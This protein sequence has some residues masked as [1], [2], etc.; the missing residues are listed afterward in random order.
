MNAA[1]TPGKYILLRFRYDSGDD[2]GISTTTG[3]YVD[4]V[5]VS[6]AV[7][8]INYS[9][10]KTDI[11]CAGVNT[12]SITFSNVFGGTPPYQYSINGGNSFSSSST[13]NGLTAASYTLVIRDAVGV[14]SYISNTTLNTLTT[15]PAPVITASGSTSFCQGGG[16]N[17]TSNVIPGVT[18]NWFRSG[19]AQTEPSNTVYA[20][21]AGNW[22]VTVSLNGC[23]RQSNVITVTQLLAPLPQSVSL[24][25]TTC[26]LNNGSLTVTTVQRGTAPFQYSI[27]GGQTF[28]TSN[29]FTGLSAGTYS[30]RVRD[31][32]QC[33]TFVTT[34]PYNFTI[35]NAP[36]NINPV[37]K[38]KNVI[39][40][41]PNTEPLP[42]NPD[43]FDDGST[44]NCGIV[45]R[46]VTPSIV[47][48]NNIG[49]VPITL[50][51]KDASGRS[52][53]ANANLTLIGPLQLHTKNIN[54]YLGSNGTVSITPSDIDSASQNFT[55]LSV[56]P[57]TFNC[58]TLGCKTV[59]LSA[60]SLSGTASASAVVTVLDTIKPTAQ[61]KNISVLLGASGTVTITPSMIDFG[62]TDNCTVT[63][64]SVHPNTFGLN[65]VGNNTVTLSVSDSSGNTSTAEAVVTVINPTPIAVSKNT[66][67][68]LN[69]SGTA[70]LLPQDI[71]NGSSNYD[72]LT[73]SKSIFNCIQA[74]QTDTVI[75]TA[76]NSY[77]SVSTVSLVT[78]LDTIKPLA[79]A[80]NISVQLG[81]NG[82]VSI[83]PAMVDFGSSDNCSISFMSVSPNSF[84]TNNVGNNTVTLLVSDASGNF[85]TTEA[86]VTVINPVPL[87]ATKNINLFLNNEGLATLTPEDIDNGSSNYEILSV[88]KTLF[89][90]A[91][92][93]NIDTVILTATNSYGTANAVSLVTVL[94]TIKPTVQVKSIT[95]SLTS[96]N[97][98]TI[99]ANEIN[100][101]SFDNCMITS[102][103]VSPST[104]TLN[105]LGQNTVTLT[106]TDASGNTSSVSAVVTITAFVAPPTVITRNRTL[107]LNS[108][109]T[110]T[111]TPSQ[112]DNGSNNYT[113]LSVSPNTFNCSNVGPNT[114]TLTATGPGGTVS[115]TAI[116]TVR[117]VT[118]PTL[119]T[120][121]ISVV[122]QNGIAVITPQ[123]IDNGSTDACGIAS[124]TLN[125]TTFTLNNSNNSGCNSH[126]GQVQNVTLTVRDVNNNTASANAFVTLIQPT[127]AK[128]KNIT[129]QLNATGTV[130]I[131]AQQVNDGSVNFTSLTVSPNTFNCS[132]VG[133]NLVVL[134]AVGP[135]GTS[136]D[137]AIVTVRD[138]NNPIARAKNLTV[139]LNNG[140]AS[141]TPADIDNG[142]T[143][144]CGIA[145]MS[146]SK[147]TF[148]NSNVGNNTVTLTV[149]DI[150][151]L[152]S[153][154]TATVTVHAPPSCNI[155]LTKGSG[156]NNF[157]P[158]NQIFLGYGNQ[159]VI[160]TAQVN[161]ATAS[162][163]S[164]SGSNINNTSGTSTTFT[165]TTTGTF[166]ITCNINLQGGG[167]VSCNTTICVLDARAPSNGNNQKIFVCHNNNTLSVS[168]N[169]VPALLCNAGARL[170]SCNASCG[171]FS[172]TNDA[173]VNAIDFALS[174]E[175]FVYP[176]PSNALRNFTFLFTS[177][178]V[179]PAT[180]TIYD[181]KGVL[182]SSELITPNIEQ[183]IGGNLNTGMYFVMVKQ[184]NYTKT[185][186]ITKVN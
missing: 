38:A 40:Q 168:I 1:V 54:A 147:T 33:T 84:G 151:G 24:T 103:V 101:G 144:A 154:A 141:I 87:A 107:N 99:L 32:N 46:T 140:S 91:Q 78:V 115:A 124:M 35:S 27:N 16:V 158:A 110:L 133:Q 8:P 39:L 68:Y 69:N 112:I 31:A 163:I 70:T 98:I 82:M 51:V 184:G 55:T 11:Q 19:F 65:N 41:M 118:A 125:K 180:I 97:T 160:L 146:L 77:S 167:S 171:S 132:N 161:N 72:V 67:L 61:A 150:N 74:G 153:T 139:M 15:I 155:N 4:N 5:V 29:T 34:N 172:K 105:N 108:Q 88:S 71:D 137:T 28:T 164:W 23:S 156:A 57:N 80:K 123:D 95:K 134:T 185:L 176:N 76:T 145:S 20:N 114:V 18:Y 49:N 152:V 83:N 117:D 60:T 127:T 165:A 169:A 149:V 59:T 121:N 122:L 86:I 181:M 159:T 53:S 186:K 178:S 44:D 130:S 177:E 56:S 22:S 148:N 106:A 6:Q 2:Y 45:E 17:L 21:T 75:L 94:D 182:V 10:T 166:T 175:V 142:S 81:N 3:W 47:T 42:L 79:L 25:S 113:T 128:A 9:F 136:H 26:N 143:D 109:G 89:N 36:D 64:M 179:E 173:P 92:A 111:I 48:L 131:N 104:F 126:G 157:A 62:S 50:T 120:K 63:S 66:T 102:L 85:S 14:L 12:G 135:T 90:C 96:N 162:S 73:V 170:G 30:V 58:S 183:I 129:V 13:F 52:S 138:L 174:Q 116:V 119:R 100:D 93:G 37:A 43:M 7:N